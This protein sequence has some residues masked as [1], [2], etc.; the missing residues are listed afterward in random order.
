MK[1]QK[2]SQK[3][4]TKIKEQQIKPKPKWQFLLNNYSLWIIGIT[5]LIIGAVAASVAI[6]Q[7]TNGDWDVL[8]L[9]GSR[10]LGFF[11]TSLP[12]F[13]LGMIILFLAFAYF[14]ITRT[15]TG[16]RYQRAALITGLITSI[17]FF[18]LSF[19][20]LNFGQSIDRGFRQK[21]PFYQRI[22]QERGRRWQRPNSGMLAGRI[23][24]ISQKTMEIKDFQGNNWVIDISQARMPFN[25]FKKDDQ[26]R[27]IGEK[28]SNGQFKARAVLPWHKPGPKRFGIKS[29]RNIK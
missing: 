29:T 3:V 15:K 13:W 14:G 26:V 2:I 5:C 17:G 7:L 4:L 1:K 23:I 27:I 6:F 25:D 21:S 10:A 19:Q 24:A 11:F 22:N 28:T 12:Y 8:S 16:Y 9:L 18:G 20:M